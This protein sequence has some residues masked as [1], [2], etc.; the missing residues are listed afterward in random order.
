MLAS[1]NA[2]GRVW[3]RV[4]ARLPLHIG[5]ELVLGLG[6]RIRVRIRVKVTGW[7]RV[8]VIINRSEDANVDALGH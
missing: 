1:N 7:G 8:G 3:A 6:F 5:L 4:R 2:C